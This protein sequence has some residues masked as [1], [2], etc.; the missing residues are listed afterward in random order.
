LVHQWAGYPRTYVRVLDDDPKAVKGVEVASALLQSRAQISNG[1][2]L[3]VVANEVAGI[4][5]L[6]DAPDGNVN[7]SV[8]ARAAPWVDVSVAEIWVNGT[9]RAATSKTAAPEQGNRIQ[10]LQRLSLTRDSWLVVTARG[11]RPLAETFPGGRGLPFAIT[12]PVF[13]DVDGDG[14]FAA[15][16]GARL[17]DK[18]V[19]VRAPPPGSVSVPTS[20]SAPLPSSVPTE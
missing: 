13:V 5:D 9:R 4:G 3:E 7:V 16:Y 14:A 17:A 12:N 20:P 19:P 15:P 18:P 10:W 2:F 11:E 6:L 1:I 8:I